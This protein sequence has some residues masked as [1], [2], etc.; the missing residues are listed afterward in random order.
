M[1]PLLIQD[2][3]SSKIFNFGNKHHFW[4]DIY[5]YY[6]SG[7]YKY[8]YTNNIVKILISYILIIV[9]NF[10]I[11]CVNYEK[12]LTLEPNEEHSIKTFI[13][14]DNWFPTNIYLIICFIIYSIY[15]ICITIDC[16][17][18]LIRFKKVKYIINNFYE[19]KDSKIRYLNWEQIVDIIKYKNEEN[20]NLLNDVMNYN[21]K[22]EI[23]EIS[24]ISEIQSSS[25]DTSNIDILNND[26]SNKEPHIGHN[27]VNINRNIT[28][29]IVN[30][31]DDNI[32]NINTILCK[33]SNIIISIFRSRI[34]TIPKISKLLE[35][36]F[37]Y[38]IVEPLLSLRIKEKDNISL[39]VT[40][41]VFNNNNTY[42]ESFI[43][44]ESLIGEH[45]NVGLN[46]LIIKDDIK[47]NYIKKVNKRLNL[48]TIINI[49]ALPFAII[50]L[51]IYIILKYGEKFYHNPKLIYERQIDLR[52]K[53]QLKYYNETIDVFDER[54]QKI[55]I[56]M[57]KIIAQYKNSISQIIYRLLI[58]I[59]GSIFIILFVLTLIGGNEFANIIL[60]DNKSILWFLS[61]IGTLLLL[62]RNSGDKQKL[63]KHERNEIIDRLRL[64]LISINQRMIE[65]DDKEYFIKLLKHIYPYKIIFIWY[66]ILYLILS[67]YYL[68][69][70]KN[71]I[72]KNC[73]KLFNL[74]DYESNIGIISKYSEFNNREEIK[75]NKHMLLSLIHFQKNNNYVIDNQ[76]NDLI[77]YNDLIQYNDLNKNYIPL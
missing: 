5:Q 58:F 34:F 45:D 46:K 25:E 14:L 47:Y 31:I 65:E 74:I 50:I 21:Y 4:T 40:E 2:L 76:Y 18:T 60:F 67:P 8:I 33:Q 77:E 39:N 12:I 28:N 61:I 52:T 30:D 20:Y 62:M 22:D 73:E 38:C 16:I 68:L 23:S 37:I 55:K 41:S 54:L 59:L 10:L 19:I 43:N 57:D 29:N 66:E 9:I 3:D 72:N 36:N 75:K 26:I 13:N 63:S 71:E 42:T 49:I 7:G 70:W 15:L 1:E 35:W 27:A 64:E 56:D 17:F 6:Y 69:L 48:V 44:N 51:G 53:W 24:E 32:Y 11:N